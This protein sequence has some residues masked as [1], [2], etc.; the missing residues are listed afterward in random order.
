MRII[1]TIFLLTLIAHGYS[2]TEIKKPIEL[3]QPLNRFLYERY[4]RNLYKYEPYLIRENRIA[5]LEVRR[6]EKIGDSVI[7]SKVTEKVFFRKDGRPSQVITGWDDNYQ[8]S[9]CTD[10]SYDSLGNLVEY[11]QWY[12]NK[13]NKETEVVKEHLVF[14]Y[15]NEQLTKVFRYSTSNGS[16]Y[17]SLNFC[18]SLSYDLNEHRLSI[19][20]CTPPWPV[21][22]YGQKPQFNYTVDPNTISTYNFIEAE[23]IDKPVDDENVWRKTDCVYYD[24]VLLELQSLTGK[25]CLNQDIVNACNGVCSGISGLSTFYH[26]EQ[27]NELPKLTFN[28]AIFYKKENVIFVDTVVQFIY[29]KQKFTTV[30]PTSLEDLVTTTSLIQ[31]YDYSMRLMHVESVREHGR[32]PEHGKDSTETFYTF[33]SSG[34][35]QKKVEVHYYKN[36][37]TITYGQSSGESSVQSMD[38]SPGMIYEEE[39]EIKTWE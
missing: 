26:F 35:M 8:D 30:K 29:V 15:M 22:V 34:L 39:I 24:P 2:Q 12:R 31:L 33:Y 38:Y 1:A 11:R 18:D 19:V 27:T 10:Y 32:G 6:T 37:Y 5:Y 28:S 14:Q 21:I 25:K 23:N 3:N 16:G 4:F 9:A 13:Y 17:L 20:P 36:Q 7:F